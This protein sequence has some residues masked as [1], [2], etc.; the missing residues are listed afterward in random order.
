M[1]FYLSTSKT[2]SEEIR[3]DENSIY[4]D[5]IISKLRTMFE[6]DEEIV[7]YLQKVNSKLSGLT[8]P[9]KIIQLPDQTKE[10]R[11]LREITGLIYEIGDNSI[12][13]FLNSAIV[14][15]KKQG[16]YL[17]SILVLMFNLSTY[18]DPLSK[19][20]VFDKGSID[21]VI[22]EFEDSFEK[23]I[24]QKSYQSIINAL[25]NDFKSIDLPFYKFLKELKKEKAPEYIEFINDDDSYNLFAH[26]QKVN[27]ISYKEIILSKEF[28]D[29]IRESDYD[30]SDFLEMDE[31]IEAFLSEKDLDETKMT[32]V[33]INAIL[34]KEKYSRHLITE[35]RIKALS[36]EP[37]GISLF[38][39]LE[40][41]IDLSP[42]NTNKHR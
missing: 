27:E 9:V 4:I 40:T 31:I 23:G 12:N 15:S 29:F 5:V 22:K 3:F 42:F 21:F 37:E 6:N 32:E 17:S 26:Y 10:E 8:N 20:K 38:D 16:S 35:D 14:A 25:N 18:K 2:C 39:V 30:N 41:N 11:L 34:T 28:Q 1:S 19:R 36:F 24:L 33:L 13:I 7:D